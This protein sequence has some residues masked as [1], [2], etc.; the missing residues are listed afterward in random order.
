M[1]RNIRHKSWHRAAPEKGESYFVGLGFIETKH[2]PNHCSTLVGHTE[3][4][5]DTHPLPVLRVC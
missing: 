3:T 2:S 5:R 4:Q 1:V